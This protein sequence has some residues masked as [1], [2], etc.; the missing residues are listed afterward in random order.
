MDGR[1]LGRATPEVNST[2]LWREMQNTEAAGQ[3]VCYKPA[4][5]Q[6][7]KE[8]HLIITGSSSAVFYDMWDSVMNG[9]V[10]S[11][12]SDMHHYECI[13]PNVDINLQSGRF[14][15]MPIA[16]F[17][18]RF[19]DFRSCWIVF[20]HVLRAV[21]MVS[22]SSPEWKLIRSAWHLIRLAFMQCG[23]RG[24]DAMLEQ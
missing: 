9:I 23:R 6:K 22:S 2:S 1:I 18:D 4:I 24:R 15:A 21:L 10:R 8:R 13:A 12:V 3:R 17:T 7:T 14:W 16:S 11:L 19:I 5:W 20:I